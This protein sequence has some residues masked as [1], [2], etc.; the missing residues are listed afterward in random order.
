MNVNAVSSVLPPFRSGAF[1]E[2]KFTVAR[3]VFSELWL[4][5]QEEKSSRT[6]AAKAGLVSYYGLLRLSIK[7]L[8]EGAPGDLQH[9][10]GT[11]SVPYLEVIDEIRK[12][13]LWV[14]CHGYDHRVH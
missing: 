3:A 14:S 8:L 10:E 1:H 12:R 7:P 5:S 9:T 4:D 6:S 11:D 2:E 13:Y